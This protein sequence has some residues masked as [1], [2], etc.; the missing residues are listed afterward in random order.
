MEWVTLLEGKAGL[1]LDVSPIST[2]CVSDMLVYITCMYLRASVSELIRTVCVAPLFLLV[3]A[4]LLIL[5]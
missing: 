1:V 2:L 4:S 5:P 3:A